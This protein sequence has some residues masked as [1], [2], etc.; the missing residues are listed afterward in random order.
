MRALGALLG[1]LLVLVPAPASA[2]PNPYD[3]P[4]MPK[5]DFSTD[6]TPQPVVHQMLRMANVGPSDFVV[7]L[8]SGDGRIP[9][10]AAKDYGARALGVD[11]NPNI[12]VVARR[13][14][15]RSGV[16][17]AVQFIEQDI[18]KTDLTGATVV[19]A[20]LWPNVHVKLRPILL[21]KL[22]PG[23]RVVTNLYHMG[24]WKADKTAHLRA[25]TGQGPHVYPIYLW[26]VPARIEGNW[27]MD[28]A[29]QRIDLKV[30]RKYQFFSGSGTVNGRVQP[31]RNGRIEGI[32]LAFEL[33]INGVR[34]RYTG[35]LQQDGTI[36]GDNWSAARN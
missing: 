11:L 13:N 18:F 2:E 30:V 31:I 32:K 29:G 16:E 3:G 12:M 23:A 24:D 9:I 28:V 6:V 25:Q 27:A 10:T 15:A 1:T 36:K 35:H 5:F 19:T 4:V 14:A 21:E 17:A 33:A 34:G 26:V 8:G 22:A 20:V 7:D